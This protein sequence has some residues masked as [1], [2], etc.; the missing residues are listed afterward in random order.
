LDW[1]LSV[2]LWTSFGLGL[3]LSIVPDG[4]TPR[5]AFAAVA[6]ATYVVTMQVVPRPTRHSDNIGELLSVVGVVIALLA[7]A[8]TDGIDSPYLLF[9]ATPSFFAGAFLGY[10]IGIETAL[11]T[12]IGFIA[13]VATL[14]QDILQGQVLQIMLLYVLIAATFAQARRV[15]IEERAVAAQVNMLRVGRLEA[16]HSALISLQELADTA[17]LNPVSVGRAAL[18][19]LALLVPYEAGQVVLDDDHG[20]VVVA[21]RG[22]PDTPESGALY[23]MEVG[24]RRLGHVTLW[25]APGDSLAG[26]REVVEELLRPVTLAYDNI[27]LLRSVAGRAVQEERMRLARDLHDDVGPSL[28]SLGLG[29][30]TAILSDETGEVLARQL[31]TM[32]RSVVTLVEKIRHIASDLRHEPATSLVEQA[33]RIAAQVGADGPAVIIDIDEQRPPRPVL[34]TDLGAIMQEA[35]RNATL[36]AAARSIRIEGSVDRGRGSL[37]IIDDGAGFDTRRR[38]QGHF[39]LIGIRERA[40]EIG[41]RINIESAPGAGTRVTVKWGPE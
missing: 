14:D 39:G 23:Y 31:E 3:F 20:P 5:A 40:E 13:V 15:L 19:D 18:R 11:L 12:S 29:L 25:P 7:T 24:S 10:R 22:E 9:L 32:R 41:A 26:Y 4:T 28:A 6:V 8:L 37:S 27:A 30:D 21:R 33:N 35:V 17:D 16:A 2:L 1:L 34:A 36:H 38:N